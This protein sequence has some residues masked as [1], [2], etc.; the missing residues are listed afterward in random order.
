MVAFYS[1][2]IDNFKYCVQLMVYFE[3]LGRMHCFYMWVDSCHWKVDPCR[4][5]FR[6]TCFRLG[7]QTYFF[8]LKL[9]KCQIAL[10]SE[11]QYVFMIAICFVSLER[12][13]YTFSSHATRQQCLYKQK[14]V[15]R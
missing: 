7:S 2:R 13:N 5:S 6:I 10:S 9:L 11:K 3:Q 12:M 8:S 14:S 4:V 15:K 1:L